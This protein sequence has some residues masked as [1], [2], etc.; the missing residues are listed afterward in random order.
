MQSWL[1]TLGA[2]ALPLAM[3][4]PSG[5]APGAAVWV[6]FAPLILVVVIFYVLVFRPQRERA[7]EHQK[8]LDNLKKGDEVLTSGGLYGRVHG[9]TEHVIVLEVAPNMKIKVAR[10][11]IESKEPSKDGKDSKSDTKSSD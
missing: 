10:Q 7:K 8:M 4:P 9:L 2:R 1:L 6:Q 11:R 5:D 3:A